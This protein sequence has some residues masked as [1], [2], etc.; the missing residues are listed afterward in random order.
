MWNKLAQ[1]VTLFEAPARVFFKEGDVLENDD[2]RGC[3]K[4]IMMGMSTLGAILS[5]MALRIRVMFSHPI[6]E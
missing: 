1:I 5:M 6:L 3:Q 4:E 2:K